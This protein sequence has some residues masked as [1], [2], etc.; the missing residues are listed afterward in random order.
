[1]SCGC[2]DLLRARDVSRAFV[3]M[4]VMRVSAEWGRGEEVRSAE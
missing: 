2:A 1:M 3:K 4:Y